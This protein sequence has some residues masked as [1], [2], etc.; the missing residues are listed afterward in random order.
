MAPRLMIISRALL[1]QV[2]VIKY[3]TQPEYMQGDS[4]L[5]VTNSGSLPED[6]LGYLL[7]MLL[8]FCLLF[9]YRDSR[10]HQTGVK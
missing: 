3:H 5:N 7:N 10:I 1:L 6:L 4:Q 9:L 2:L 8:Q